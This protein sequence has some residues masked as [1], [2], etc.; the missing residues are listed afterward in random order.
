[1]IGHLFKLVWNRRRSN[2]LILFE[3]LISFL[4]LCAVLTVACTF[5][6]H[7]SQPLGFDY[8]DVY[9]LDIEI[10]GYYD[11]DDDDKARTWANIDQLQLLLDNMEQVDSHSPMPWNLPF[12]TSF[13]GSMN[14]IN[15]ISY[16]IRMNEVDSTVMDV[17]EMQVVAGRWLEP[18]DAA[19]D[20]QPVVLTSNYAELLFGNDVPLGVKVALWDRDKPAE[21]REENQVVGVI[22]PLR[23]DGELAPPSLGEFSLIDFGESDRPPTNFLLR[24]RPGVPI[25]FEEELSR[26]ITGIAPDWTV[27][28]STL[29]KHRS[30]QLE[31][32]LIPLLVAAGVA[33][34]LLVMVGLGLV[35]VLW[36]MVT[37][38]TEEI[39]LRRALG[40]SASAIRRQVLGELLAL[41]TLT[42]GIGTLIYLQ[43]PLLQIIGDIP[44][45]V[46]LVALTLSLLVLYSFVILCGLYPSWLATR[47]RPAQALQYE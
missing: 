3:L 41:L 6:Y 29:A 42:T 11:L 38:R 12:G 8:E 36:Q 13:S 5:H 9:R 26:A 20:P 1:M 45:Q 46:Y 40:A 37:R 14:S 19:V 34:F 10:D 44:L 35:G 25:E 47:V 17:L 15:G 43:F 33:F 39:G 18:G 32:H 22:Q 31:I 28:L 30:Q 16:R 4:G 21:E 23:L 27:N 24:L 7:W 2:L